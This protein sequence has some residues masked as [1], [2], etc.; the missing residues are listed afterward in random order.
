MTT[1]DKIKLAHEHFKDVQ[2]KLRKYGASDTEPNCVYEVAIRNAIQG[3]PFSPFT[4][5][6]WQLY[7]CGMNCNL[8]AAR[9]NHALQRVVNT[10]ACA[11]LGERPA[12]IDWFKTW[13]WRVN[14]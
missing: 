12:I 2:H 5:D 11:K 3:S 6:G 10:I 1:I 8:A 9:L 13:A 14:I 4:A 7:T